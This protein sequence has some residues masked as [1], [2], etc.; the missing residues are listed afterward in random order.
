MTRSH[1]Q[2]IHCDQNG[3]H[4][5]LQG[6]TTS[7]SRRHMLGQ[8]VC[9]L[10]FSSSPL[11]AAPPKKKSVT[12][13]MIEPA[14]FISNATVDQNELRFTYSILNR[15]SVPI[16]LFNLIDEGY[17]SKF[18]YKIN[19]QR[20]NVQLVH[21]TALISKKIMPV[22]ADMDVE[23]KNIPCVTRVLPGDK[24]SENL[25]LPLPL[26]SWTPYRRTG[27][28]END[29]RPFSAHAYF[30]IGYFHGADRTDSLAKQERTTLGTRQRFSA[31][32]EQKQK[33]VKAPILLFPVMILD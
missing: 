19:Q 17:D 22:P 28:A 14:L 23:M 26:Q 25:M 6:P 3:P 7:Q 15:A 5:N 12:L 33:T 4:H 16:Y 1:I 31:F 32:S 9:A 18:G 24:F 11:L 21:S 8:A 13:K 2:K 10:V 27:S 30:E 29:P 20:C